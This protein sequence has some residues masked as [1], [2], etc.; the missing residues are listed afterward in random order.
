MPDTA[1]IS[2]PMID[3]PQFLR[4]FAIQDQP[5]LMVFLGAGASVSAGI[6]TAVDMTWMFKRM[7]YCSETGTDE[8]ALRDLSVERHQQRLQEYFDRNKG[9]PKLWSDNEYSF[10]FEKAF[11]DPSDRRIFIRQMLKAGRPSIGHECLAALVAQ[12]RC[13]WI[14]T[15]NFDDLVER[16]ERID[17]ERCFH[18]LRPVLATILHGILEG[19]EKHVLVMMIEDV[20]T[21]AI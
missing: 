11:P 9:F 1:S 8:E 10:Y 20:Y 2:I 6:P 19:I 15:T 13:D 4:A 5:R 3:L 12:A 18:E 21:H 14:W 17:T 7:I 16:D